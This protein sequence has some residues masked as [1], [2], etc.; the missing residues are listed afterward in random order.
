MSAD[1]KRMGKQTVRLLETPSVYGIGTVA[2]K[3]EAE[4][5]IGVYFDSVSD[6]DGG[7]KGSFELDERKMLES[8][9]DILLNKTKIDERDVDYILMGDLLNQIATSAYTARDVAIPYIGVYGAC[10]T[11][12]LSLGLAAILVDG[13][14]ADKTIAATCSHF[15]TAE[16]QYRYPLEMGVQRTESSQ[17]T[18]T[19]AGAV[20]VGCNK[21]GEPYISY[22][23]TGRVT[24]YEVTDVNNMGAA[25]APA[26]VN[27][28]KAHFAETGRDPS[29]Y[30]LITTGDLG[31]Y[32]KQI[33]NEFMRED[34]PDFEERYKDCGC[35]L[36]KGDSAV[37]AGASG[38]GCSALYLAKILSEMKSGMLKRVLFTST[39]AL[40]NPTMLFQKESIPGIAHSVAIEMI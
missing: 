34:Y 28:L 20:L 30:D 26:A 38:C 8:A 33:V 10:S 35:E 25:M 29:Y 19:G 36:F 18:A 9:V 23:T 12:A 1:N 27:T 15:C 39:G 14:Y 11:M 6:R 16:R 31:I 4:G 37:K 17:W 21:P 32:G 13:G 3:K 2:G 22:V 40:H 5:P 24:D 7:V